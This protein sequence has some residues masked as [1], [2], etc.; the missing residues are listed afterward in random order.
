MP[1]I[2][3]ER[4]HSEYPSPILQII[5]TPQRRQCIQNRIPLVVPM[6]DDVEHTTRQFHY[7]ERMFETLMRSAWVNEVCQS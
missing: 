2:M 4:R 5:W 1:D 7:S 3:A 6:R